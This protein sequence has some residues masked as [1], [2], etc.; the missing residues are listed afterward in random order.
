ME[1]SAPR[2][3]EVK[4]FIAQETWDSTAQFQGLRYLHHPARAISAD[5]AEMIR[6]CFL[7]GVRV[8]VRECV[9]KYRASN[10][11]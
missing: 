8:C 10:L 1:I 9:K 4:R 3:A 11:T 2:K 5:A 6:C 7:C